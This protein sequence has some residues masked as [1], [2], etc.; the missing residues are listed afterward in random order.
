MY[1]IHLTYNI[2]RDMK[3][4]MDLHLRLTSIIYVC[5]IDLVYTLYCQP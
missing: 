3:L 2:N 1:S 4:Y 5:P